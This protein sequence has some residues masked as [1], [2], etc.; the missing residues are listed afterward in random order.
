MFDSVQPQ[1]SKVL[2]SPFEGDQCLAYP[3]RLWDRM[4]LPVFGKDAHNLHLILFA[5]AC[6]LLSSAVR[7]PKYE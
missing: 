2:H 7:R 5:K 6:T 3:L 4:T 1:R